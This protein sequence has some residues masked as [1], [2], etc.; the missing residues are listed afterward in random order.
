MVREERPRSE[1]WPGLIMEVTEDEIVRDLKLANEVAAELRRRD[2]RLR[3]TISA[4][5]IPRSRGCSSFRSA[6]SRSTALRDQLPHRQ[7]Q[8]RAV[9][10]VRRTRAS[11]SASRP[12]PRA[13]RP[14]HESHKLQALGCDVGQGY[15]FAK[16]MPKDQLIGTMRR[17]L[18]ASRPSRRDALIARRRQPRRV[19][20]AA[21]A[22]RDRLAQRADGSIAAIALARPAT[23]P[24]RI[25]DLRVIARA[26]Y[27]SGNQS[28]RTAHACDPPPRLGNS[29]ARRHSRALFLNRRTFLAAA[30]AAALS[31]SPELAAA[32]RVTDLPDPTADLY[33]A[34]RNEKYTLD[35]PVTDEKI[36]TNYNN[37]YEFGST[38][39]SRARRRRCR[40]GPGRSR[41]T[42]WSRSRR[43]SASTI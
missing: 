33:P 29:R 38:R 22:S 3:S 17:R 10:G 43:R 25:C 23:P 31:L 41:S 24:S 27:F 1:N 11:A 19:G 32:Q 39:R 13:S 2:A 18:V 7:G 34:K 21:A 42:A 6:S 37:F 30:G 36:D 35:R 4:P 9:R 15:L 12:W 28:R 14:T 26:K 20:A 5:A 16:P 40:S 8:C